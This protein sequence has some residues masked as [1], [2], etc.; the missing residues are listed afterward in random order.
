MSYYQIQ[1]ILIPID[2]S[3]TSLKALDHAA[4]LAKLSNAEITLLHVPESLSTTSGTG[5]FDPPDFHE[6]YERSIEEQSN[7]KL[8]EIADGLKKK[9]NT[10]VKTL[11]VI[12]NPKREI[13]AVS[14][15][16]KADLIV[17]GTHGRTGLGRL[18]MGSVAESVLRTAPCPVVTV[19]AP[20]P[21]AEPSSGA[22]AAETVQ[23]V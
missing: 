13:L 14:K 22:K 23:P 11:T 2:F 20:L 5:L 1:R 16:I 3:K 21:E 7:A 8:N 6:D 12:G 10:R 9:G 17:M 4:Y 18:L 15:K 19:K